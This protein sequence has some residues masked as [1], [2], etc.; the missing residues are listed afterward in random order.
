MYISLEV[1]FQADDDESRLKYSFVQAFHLP[2][3]I[4]ALVPM[5]LA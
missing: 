4:F 1:S 2:A 3:T 5:P